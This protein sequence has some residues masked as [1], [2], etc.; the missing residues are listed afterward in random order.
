MRSASATLLAAV[1]VSA[2]SPAL[3]DGNN[4]WVSGPEPS[5]CGS[6][7]NAGAENNPTW[8]FWVLGFWSGMNWEAANRKKG[9]TGSTTDGDGV[10]LSV[11]K[12]CQDDPA[13]SV[14]F[15]IAKMHEQF[16][17]DAR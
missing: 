14:P 9:V 4:V 17:K 13:L 10:V 11:K 1:L 16:E 15:V 6:F 12:R 2:V 5:S 8:R 7:L 3:S